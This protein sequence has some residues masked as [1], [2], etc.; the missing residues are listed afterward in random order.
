MAIHHFLLIYSLVEHRLLDAKDLG[1]D[2]AAAIDAYAE[3]E[4]QYRGQDGIE[5]VLI[6]ADSLETIRQTHAHYFE[7]NLGGDFFESVVPT[8][9]G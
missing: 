7:G 4:A 2:T 6:G 5:I 3:C 8:T 9:A 1:Q